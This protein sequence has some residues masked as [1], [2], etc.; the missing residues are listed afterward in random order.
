MGG[1]K[2]VAQSFLHEVSLRNENIEYH[3][4]LSKQ[5]Q[6]ELSDKIFP[7][8]FI[9]YN[10]L[11]KPKPFFL[12]N[13]AKKE[14]D[15][16]EEI[17][18]PNVV[19]SIFGP[20]YWSPKTFHVCGFADG[21]VINPE[22]IAFKRLSRIQWVKMKLINLVKKHYLNNAKANLYI[23][24]TGVVKSK[25]AKHTSV[26]ADNIFVVS[27]TYGD[28]YNNIKLNTIPLINKFGDDVFKFITI[29]ANYPHKNLSIIN[30]V[31]PYFI[32]ENIKV[33]FFVTLSQTDYESMFLKNKEYVINLGSLKSTDC[34]SY[35]ISCNALFLPT[36]LESFTASYPE[37]M[38]MKLPIITSDLDFAR[39]LCGNAALFCDTLNPLDVYEKMKLLIQDKQLQEK[40]VISGDLELNRFESAKNRAEKYLQICG[41]LNK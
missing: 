19:L 21:W 24:E 37:A 1:A 12:G 10:I 40:L 4:F 20:A 35:Y 11:N 26:P 23:V 15:K 7:T 2:Q 5:M 36:L 39:Y 32:K 14:L 28:Q 27:N 8:N 3:V 38:K 18:K 34:P 22:S 6:D 17:I 41:V 29:S 25:L 30:A 16:L 33:K 9:F 31:I 13:K